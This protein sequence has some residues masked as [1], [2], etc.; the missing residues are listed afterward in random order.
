MATRESHWLNHSGKQNL[1][2]EA[3]KLRR[4]H[5]RELIVKALKDPDGDHIINKKHGDA[6]H[7]D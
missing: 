6:W 2:E 4:H 7:W 1:K 3:R 5:E